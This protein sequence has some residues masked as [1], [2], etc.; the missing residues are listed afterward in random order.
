MWYNAPIS[1]MPY[2]QHLGI[3][4]EWIGAILTKYQPLGEDSDGKSSPT[5]QNDHSTCG[6]LLLPVPETLGE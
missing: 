3:G 4:R 5:L 1:G 2:L 6:P